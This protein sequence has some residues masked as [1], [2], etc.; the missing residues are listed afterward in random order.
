MVV[1]VVG[2]FGEEAWRAELARIGRE[3]EAEAAREELDPA[4][5]DNLEE[6]ALQ[7]YELGASA[8]YVVRGAEA[9]AM[10]DTDGNALADHVT[11][12]VFV[13][14]FPKLAAGETGAELV[15]PGAVPFVLG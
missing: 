13:A 6:V 15:D 14:L 3:I 12:T 1:D 9:F 7:C 8:V 11:Q 5:A 2:A 10:R 4:L